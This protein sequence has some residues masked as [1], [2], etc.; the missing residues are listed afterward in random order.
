MDPHTARTDAIVSTALELAEAE[1]VAKIT[2][3]G[4]ARGLQFTE[5]ALYRYFPGKAAI[6]ASAFQRLGEHLL[7]TMLIELMPEAVERGQ[8]PE[9]QL[10]Q[11]LERF[12]AR[13]GLLPELLVAAAGGREPELHV[14]GSEFLQTYGERMLAYFSALQKLG[15][16]ASSPDAEELARL[17]ICQLLGG[18]IRC[19]LAREAWDPTSQSGF[20]TFLRLVRF[21]SPVADPV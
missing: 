21:R 12:S 3:A 2:T 18:F 10:Q 19:R 17:W 20:D 7:A 1:G 4:L 11:H 8:S 6:I 5:A 14:A 9:T 15:A 13:H 16:M